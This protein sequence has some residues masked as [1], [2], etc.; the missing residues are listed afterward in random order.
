MASEPAVVL[1]RSADENKALSVRLAAHG[2]ATV[3]APMIDVVV[4]NDNTEALR[5]AISQL[6]SFQWL[7]FTSANG[8]RSFDS[9]YKLNTG[10]AAAHGH[11]AVVVVGPATRDAVLHAT[12]RQTMSQ[13]ASPSTGRPTDAEPAVGNLVVVEQAP[14]LL[15][16]P[17]ATAA[18]LVSNFPDAVSERL[19]SEYEPSPLKVL[20]VLGQLADTTVQV[21]LKAKGYDVSRVDAY[22]NVRP[23][24]VVEVS[25]G[26]VIAFFSPS[27][28]DR[29]VERYGPAWSAVCIGPRTSQRAKTRGIEVVAIAEPHTEAGVIAALQSLFES[30]SS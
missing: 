15:M 28:V 30:R 29:F 19:P 6:D 3:E 1:T 14:R 9:V 21:G 4:S 18:D 25:P 5:S 10:L 27:A 23:E 24:R 17:V 22:G 2:I 16:A 8:V 12:F 26:S 11:L 13:P 20:A 7:V